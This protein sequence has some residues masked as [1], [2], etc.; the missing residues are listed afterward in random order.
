MNTIKVLYLQQ[1]NIL[2]LIMEYNENKNNV[3]R[4]EIRNPSYERLCE[5]HGGLVA[6]SSLLRFSRFGYYLI[7][8]PLLGDNGSCISL[9]RALRLL[10][11][12]NLINSI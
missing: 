7:V 8:S 2:H 12:D 4:I 1:N 10:E 5:V 6:I 3:Y 9:S 11:E